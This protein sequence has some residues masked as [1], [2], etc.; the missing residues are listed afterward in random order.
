[1]READG[2]R[3]RPGRPFKVGTT[4]M[5]R[6]GDVTAP[7]GEWINCRCTLRAVPLQD[8]EAAR[9]DTDRSQ[10]G[11]TMNTSIQRGT[12]TLSG[13][14][15]VAAIEAAADNTLIPWHGVLTVEGEWS[16]DR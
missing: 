13:A 5:R 4:T 3:V 1:H 9:V 6:P 8:N 16:G 12:P 10:N 11:V 2:Q 7:I 14:S 15:L